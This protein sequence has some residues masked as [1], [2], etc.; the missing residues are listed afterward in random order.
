[1]MTYNFGEILLMRFPFTDSS[2]LSKR[3]AVVLYDGGD[4]D[5]LLCR[6]T[7]QPHFSFTD[8]KVTDWRIG[9]LL[10]ESYVRVEKMATLEKDI[11]SRKLGKLVPE[12][13]NKIKKILKNMFDI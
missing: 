3:P 8:F 2:R 5:I 1:M 12:D 11:I 10:R 4:L 9:G 13:I 7:T 6:V